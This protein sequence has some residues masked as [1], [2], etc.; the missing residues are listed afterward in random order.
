MVMAKLLD[1]VV[2]GV[3]FLMS[4]TIWTESVSHSRSGSSENFAAFSIQDIEVFIG[5]EKKVSSQ[6]HQY[7]IKKEENL[8]KMEAILASVRYQQEHQIVKYEDQPR[9][10]IAA[11]TLL[12]RFIHDWSS[13]TKLMTHQLGQ[14]FIRN[15]RRRETIL[16]TVVDWNYTIKSILRLQTT[17]NLTAKDLADGKIQGTKDLGIQLNW[18]DCTMIANA[19][20]EERGFGNAYDWAKL[21]LKLSE[22]ATDMTNDVRKEIIRSLSTNA[23]QIGRTKEAIG[24][25]QELLK[26]D[27]N[28]TSAK[29]GYEKLKSALAEEATN[30][31]KNGPN[32]FQDYVKRLGR[33]DSTR[34]LAEN[35][36]F[37]NLC[38][39][40]VKEEFQV[41]LANKTLKCYYSNQSPL[42][43]L[44]PI[45]VEEISLDPFIV[46]YYDIINDHQI[47]TIKKI[48]RKK[49][50]NTCVLLLKAISILAA[51]LDENI[52]EVTKSLSRMAQAVTGLNIKY[53]EHL[54]VA[55]YGIGGHY[56]PHYDYTALKFGTLKP[57]LATLMYYLSDVEIGGA[58]V[59]PFLGITVQPRK[60]SAIYWINLYRN[61]TTHHYHTFHGGCPVLIGSKWIANRWINANGQE[62]RYPCSLN[63]HE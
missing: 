36:E 13:I 60:G 34:R 12:K 42:L 63:S 58:T 26:L 54:Q 11:Y 6:L 61:A 44:A 29:D 27:P 17:Y 59:F 8:Q 50:C 32:H 21:A 1:L 30:V 5:L 31:L 38:R 56:F 22:N 18:F 52:S 48:S 40:N 45:P 35:T 10:P 49:E 53:S 43:Y 14:D 41:R 16:P 23:F 39:G 51:W 47:E 57:R 3:L 19:A 37:G 2:I 33:A 28:D 4:G 24:Y 55:N 7:L 9:Y 25:I 46:I 62:L 15:L 20:N